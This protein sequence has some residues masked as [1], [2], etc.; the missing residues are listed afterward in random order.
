MDMW[1]RWLKGRVQQHQ[2][3]VFFG[4]HKPV[5]PVHKTPQPNYLHPTAHFDHSENALF[6]WGDVNC[7]NSVP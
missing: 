7:G 4:Y 1:W 5:Q 2:L 6:V 3:L